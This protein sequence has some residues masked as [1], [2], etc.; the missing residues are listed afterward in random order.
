MAKRL[1]YW[2]ILYAVFGTVILVCAILLSRDYHVPWFLALG[3]GLSS[4]LVLSASFGLLLFWI[5]K[6][7]KEGKAVDSSQFI[8]LFG[9]SISIR[10]CLFVFIT[11]LIFLFHREHMDFL[12]IL[13]LIY[14]FYSLFCEAVPIVLASSK[15]KNKD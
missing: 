13:F 7:K 6:N 4:F 5:L 14:F 8:R 9:I 10:L 12:Y 1:I 15:T 11:T 3:Y 2:F